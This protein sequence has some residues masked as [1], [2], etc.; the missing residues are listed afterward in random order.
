[1]FSPE[2]GRHPIFNALGVFQKDFDKFSECFGGFEGYGV[3]VWTWPSPE[4][5]LALPEA[6]PGQET[7]QETVMKP[8][9]S[10]AGGLWDLSAEVPQA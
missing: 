7:K 6:H 5:P 9:T 10:N 4:A 1:M 3:G 8:M 2:S